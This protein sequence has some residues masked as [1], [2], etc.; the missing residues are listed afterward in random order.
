MA[1]PLTYIIAD[2]DPIYMELTL[3]YLQ[4]IP[5]LTCLA[6]CDNAFEA[7]KQLKE[8]LPDLLILDVEMPGLSGL[9]LAKS[10][11]RLP[12]IIFITSHSHYA[13]DAFEVDAIDFLIKPVMPERLIRA[14]EKARALQEMKNFILPHEGFKTSNGLSF[15]IKDKNTFIKINYSDVLYIESLGDFVNIFL[16]D[17][18]KKIAL[19]SMKNLQQ[20]LPPT[21]F[22][23]IS[24]THMVNKDK[25]TA[26]ETSM[27]QLDKIQLVI[28]KTYAEIVLQ[29]VIGNTAVKRFL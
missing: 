27:L 20:Q 26:I 28:G 16:K 14:V 29:A 12:L 5:D 9:Q 1:Y 19:V 17:G 25:I 23:R 6:S 11:T 22:I 18:E 13:A 7:S 21:H 2:D 15:F 10:L 8:F 3:Q 4:M 24:R